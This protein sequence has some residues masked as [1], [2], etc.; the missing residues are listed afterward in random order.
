MKCDCGAVWLRQWMQA[1]RNQSSAGVEIQMDDCVRPDYWKGQRLIDLP[2]NFCQLHTNATAKAETKA[3]P[4][5]IA[6]EPTEDIVQYVSLGATASSDAINVTL[7]LL[8]N[9]S[10][11]VNWTITYRQ[12]G[13]PKPIGSPITG[14]LTNRTTQTL[15]GLKA[16]TGYHVCVRLEGRANYQDSYQCLEVTTPAENATSYPVTEVAVAA[17]VS[18]STTL[19]VVILVCCC[20]PRVKCGKKNKKLQDRS[21]D[22]STSSSG[23]GERE[24]EPKTKVFSVTSSAVIESESTAIWPNVEQL[25]PTH[26]ST[27]HGN[28]TLGRHHQQRQQRRPS[29][30]EQSHK[31]FQAT[32]NYLRQR[33]LDPSRGMGI[34]GDS[35]HLQI[36]QQHRASG[37]TQQVPV[38]LAP[39]ADGQYSVVGRPKSLRQ[40]VSA[41]HYFNSSYG[42]SE[43]NPNQ[44]ASL[45]PDN[46]YKYCTWRP[47]K[48]SRP[49]LSS[50]TSY[51]DFLAN[52]G[53]FQHPLSS[54]PL[55]PP[56]SHQPAIAVPVYSLTTACRPRRKRDR[57]YWSAA[58]APIHTVELQF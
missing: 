7:L 6:Q 58:P 10:T 41:M 44:T 24:A 27:F 20:C 34:R 57:F 11:T 30:E 29:E 47:V 40:Q 14:L 37:S 8:G 32:C 23:G 56:P 12:F 52:S 3:S 53:S 25:Q 1:Q 35:Q 36:V 2:L 55:P 4:K 5:S 17:S 19:V 49:L 54:L 16:T 51:P 13:T 28:G 45:P 26:F 18:T 22:G 46:P 42:L 39:I 38:Y 31:V 43:F 15:V 48:Q 50:W 21:L 33:A 9:I